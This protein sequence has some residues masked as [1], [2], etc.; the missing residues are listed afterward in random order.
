MFIKKVLSFAGT[1]GSFITSGYFAT[2]ALQSAWL[3]AH[4][5]PQHE[6]LKLK[7]MFW[8]TGTVCIFFLG[9]TIF[10][11]TLMVRQNKQDL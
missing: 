8:L 11:I 7:R 10:F 4:P 5:Y 1:I 3:T 9:M 2:L 6:I